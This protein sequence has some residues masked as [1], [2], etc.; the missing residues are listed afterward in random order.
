MKKHCIFSLSLMAII[1]L[2]VITT[3]A[4]I[5]SY[6]D[7]GAWHNDTTWIGGIVPG[8]SDN[9]VIDGNVTLWDDEECLDLTINSGDTLQNRNGSYSI[10]F[11]NGNLTN[12]G[13]IQDNSS[14]NLSLRVT[15]DITNNGIW[16]NEETRLDGTGPQHITLQAGKVFGGDFWN[17]NV[18]DTIIAASDLHFTGSF[19]LGDN[20]LNLDG[21]DIRFTGTDDNYFGRGTILSPGEFLGTVNMKF[22]TNIEG[23]LVVTDTMQ[24]IYN[25]SSTVFINGNLTNNGIIQ[26]NSSDNLYLYVT[27]DIT[28]N[29]IWQNE[30]TRL[31]GTGPQHITLQAGKVFGGDFW[32]Y[33][34]TDTIIAASDLHFTGSFYLGDNVLN[35]DG[36]DIRFTGTDDNYFGRGTILS[37]GEFLGTVNMYHT[38]NIEGNLVVTDTM[39][40]IYNSSSTVFIN[41][42][43]TNN[44]II[45]DNS[46]DNLYLYVTGDI[47][48]NGIWQNEETRLDGTGPQHITLQAGK[49]FGGDFSNR[50]V[51]D[52]IIAANDLHFT[53]SFNLY[54]NVLNLDGYDIRFTGTDDN[55]FGRGTILSPGEFLGTVNMYHTTNIEGN[56]VVTDTLQNRNGSHSTVFINGNLTNNGIIQD[57]GWTNL[58]LRVTGDITNNGIWQNEETRLDGTGPQH[59]TLQAGKVFGGDFSNYNVTDTIIAANDLH[60]TGSFNLYDN[61]LNLDGYDIRF[62]GTDDNYFGYGTILSP[63][64]F[65]GTVN[66]GFTTNIEGNLVVTDTLQNRNVSDSRVFIN[67]N[68]T[69]NGII[70][71]NSFYELDL[72]I[73]GD[74]TNN[75]IWQN[76]ETKLEGTGPQHI[77]LQSGKVFGGDFWNYNDT[78]T[79]IAANDLHFTGSFDLYDNVLNLDGYD[80][81]FTGT[82]DNYFGYGTI[83]SPGEFLGTVNMYN[84]TNIEGNLVVTDT[85]QNRNGSQSTVSINGNLT[86]NGIIQ[87]NS[88]NKFYLYVTG[89]ITNNGIWQNEETRL[90]GTGP[91]HITLQSGK[92]FGGD[93][94]NYNDT[95]TIIAANDLHFTGSFNLY[96]N[97]L[98][99]DGYDIRFTGTDDNYF[100]YGTIL[101]PGEFLGTVNMYNT[102]NIEGN[103]VV[104]DTLQNRNGSQSTVSIN[105]NLTNNGII[106]DNSSNKF[107]LYVTGDITNNGIWQN[108][109]TRLDGTGPQHITLQSGKVFGGDFSNYNDTDTIIAANDLHFTG[110]FNLYDNVLNLDGYDIRFTGTDDNYFGYGTILSPGEFLGTVNMYNTTNIEG[111]LVVTDTMQNYNTNSTV[112]INGNLTNNGIIQD[113]GSNKFY[114]YVTGDIT[115]NGIWQNEETRLDGTGP[116]HITLQS[117]KVFGGDFS[118]YNDTDTIIAANDLHFTGSFD[119]YDNVLN[120]DGY[121]IRFTGTDDNYFGYGTILSPGEFLGT[122]NM[123]NTTNIEGNLVV[124]DTMQNYNTNSTV[125]INGNLTNNGIIQDNSSDNLYLYVTGDMT[126]NGNWDN[127]LT[128]FNGSEDQRIRLMCELQNTG[129]VR[130][131]ANNVSSPY[132]WYFNST[133]LDSPYFSGEN[134]N[135]LI[136]EGPMNDNWYGSFHCQTSS[137]DSRNIIV[138]GGEFS[139]RFNG[140]DAYVNCGHDASLNLTTNISLEAWIN[141]AG[142]GEQVDYGFGRVI[143]KKKFKLFLNDAPDLYNEHSLV[144]I[145]HSG[146][147]SYSMN[148]PAGSIELDQWQHVAAT[149]DGNGDVHV[150]INGIEQLLTGTPPPGNIDDHST[151]DLLIGENADL[152]RAFDGDIDEVR[153]W[154]SVL[155]STSIRENMYREITGSESGLVSYWKFNEDTGNIAYD[156]AGSNDGTIYNI[157]GGDRIISTTPVPFYTV[158]DG[159]W[160]SDTAWAAGQKAPEYDWTRANISDSVEINS[161]VELIEL[162]LDKQSCLIINSGFRLDVTGSENAGGSGS[163]AFINFNRPP[164][165]PNKPK[166]SISKT[167]ASTQVELR[168]SCSDPDGDP[169]SYDIYLGTNNP[170]TT[171]V[172]DDQTDNFYLTSYPNDANIYWR[173]VAFDKNDNSIA[174]PT[175]DLSANEVQNTPNPSETSD[176]MIE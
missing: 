140:S 62:T 164:N 80:I 61:V 8:A 55:Y 20:V 31:D 130:F 148:T 128:T 7:G 141:P 92:V 18:T 9:V 172:A 38:T 111:N 42:N 175:W 1:I 47:T 93:F 21:Y 50:N 149:Y 56:L 75:G 112:S 78:D 5:T 68:L 113:N 114:L 118:N 66:M 52:T 39:Q 107:Y 138:S 105:G 12:N 11:I 157:S 10:V 121:D 14:N 54:D 98:N 152:S 15:G 35:L 6:P 145:I 84:T 25:S 40:N 119:L 147:G 79:I 115:N 117:G 169:M 70:Q 108:E 94:S 74:I 36:Y 129:E 88:S 173:V 165:Q 174:G 32:N 26:D 63:G 43:L 158:S 72:S 29:G 116:Q 86:N 60:F 146:E 101:S 133:I 89:D 102:T 58:S 167:D 48:N 13:I 110:S 67:G 137:R 81:R 134:S 85:L 71:N 17:Y 2:K 136:W 126:N 104:T 97:V 64:E 69:N 154:S 132:Q 142:W 65:L 27:G 143:D 46:S 120:L 153:Y 96:D 22:T 125:S 176:H 159:N 163:G 73:T 34:V 161:N 87:D 156:F 168:W 170:P 49:V 57:N 28:N 3:Q 122:V 127:E 155:D 109:E 103:L 139:F 150:Y 37:P 131:E 99:L 124:T 82:D 16:Q 4:Q 151:Y 95:D 91:Q 24:N 51:T 45:Q 171:L 123:Y 76:E 100:G 83:L 19:Y 144:F 106:Q 59:I 33:N 77:T 44:G 53:G 162:K 160:E 23:N 135:Q 30:E 41:G 90:D 166:V